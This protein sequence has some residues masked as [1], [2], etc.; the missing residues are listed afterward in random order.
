MRT[1]KVLIFVLFTYCNCN[2]VSFA[3]TVGNVTAE[4]CTTDAKGGTSCP[5]GK[6][7]I[8]VQSAYDGS[9]K[10]DSGATVMYKIKSVCIG[11]DSGIVPCAS[12]VDC[13]GVIGSDR[14]IISASSQAAFKASANVDGTFGVCGAMGGS[15]ER[16]VFVQIICVL[17]KLMTGAAGRAVVV[18]VIIATAVMFFIGKISWN[19][20][21]ATALGCGM[22]FG[23]PSLVKIFAG[24]SLVCN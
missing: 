6:T 9:L 5:E 20:M 13:A 16:N 19:M 23:A 1:L 2:A 22:L 14:C 15:S 11:N 7:C 21:L 10:T 8:A 18:V 3:A 4:D 24:K 17:I 12:D